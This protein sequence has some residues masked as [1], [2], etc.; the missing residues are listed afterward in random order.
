MTKEGLRRWSGRLF[1]LATLVFMVLIW[2]T[3]RIGSH[4]YPGMIYA[5]ITFGVMVLL[6]AIGTLLLL[7]SLFV[8][9]REPRS[10]P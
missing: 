5:L 6:I 1:I 8:R 3:A 9:R 10:L 7:V 2:L 4:D